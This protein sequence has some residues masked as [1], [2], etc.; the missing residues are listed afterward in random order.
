MVA[1]AD[2][3]GIVDL[4]RLGAKEEPDLI[5]NCWLKK[6][7]ADHIVELLNGE[8]GGAH[9]RTISGAERSQQIQLGSTTSA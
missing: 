3:Y 7:T 1:E 2:Y 5:I 8:L 4:D 6:E 9:Y